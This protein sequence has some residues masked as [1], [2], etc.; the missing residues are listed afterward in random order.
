MGKS[1]THAPVRE[2]SS[3]S[4]WRLR[5]RFAVFAAAAA[6]SLAGFA[7]APALATSAHVAAPAACTDHVYP[8]HPGS[9]SFSIGIVNTCRFPIQA[10]ALCVPW[11][12]LDLFWAYGKWVYGDGRST[13]VCAHATS[14]LEEWGYFTWTGGTSHFF[15]IGH[16]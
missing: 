11:F 16:F 9:A 4:R 3:R 2:H 7:A 13:A 12:R 14:F 5:Y 1:S 6:M 10:A 15:E 8:A